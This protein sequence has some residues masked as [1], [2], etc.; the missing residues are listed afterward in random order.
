[1]KNKYRII[2]WGFIL[3]ICLSCGITG[4]IKNNTIFKGQSDKF[5]KII[6]NF[7]NS[8][9]L[10][11]YK[12]REINIKARLKGKNIVVNYEGMQSKTFKFINKE[13]YLEVKYSKDDNFGYIIV[14]LMT[15]SISEY[16]NQQDEI[17]YPLF[18]NQEVMNYTLKDGIEI[19]T[20]D[21]DYIVKINL[22]TPL[23]LPTIEN[24]TKEEIVPEEVNEEISNENNEENE[25]TLEE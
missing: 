21:N 14:M 11:D 10:R 4:I 20:K 17:V 22:D 19:T 25:N 15:D 23:L 12:T 8:T 9:L 1:M 24:N 3:L 7:N 16:Y 6:E 18:N 5:N 2:F 13:N